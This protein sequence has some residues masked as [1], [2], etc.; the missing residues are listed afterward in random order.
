MDKNLELYNASI[1]LLE[2][3]KFLNSINHSLANLI[4]QY[5]DELL[6]EIV[7]DENEFKEIDKYEEQLRNICN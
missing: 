7:I 5:A 4:L 2:A 1:H 3:G 6:K